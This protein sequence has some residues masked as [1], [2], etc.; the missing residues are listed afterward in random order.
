MEP[1][2]A[3]QTIEIEAIFGD[4]SVQ[5][6]LRA[7]SMV[8]GAGRE[9][10][11]VLMEDAYLTMGAVEVQSDRVVLDGTVNCQVVYCQ[12][13][14]PSAR[15]LT[16]QKT[17]NHV[18]EIPGVN[19]TMFSRTRGHVEHVDAEYE[20]GHIVFQVVV[21][22]RVQVSQLEPTDVVTMLSG[23][24]GLETQF[25][26]VCSIKLNA[27]A[28]DT[29]IVREEVALPPELDAR[30]AL[31]DWQTVHVNNSAPDI[32]G[33]RV[34]GEVMTETLIGTGV[35]G[36]PAALVKVGV[37][38][39]QLVEMPEWLTTDVTAE[40]R[41]KRLSTS[42]KANE[43]GDGTKLNIEAEMDFS[44]RSSGKDCA[45]A[46][47]DAYSTG[48][49]MVVAK[50]KQLPLCGGLAQFSANETFKG[51]MLM[52]DG[53]P[54]AST[55]LAARVRPTLSGWSS[56]SGYTTFEGVLEAG[57][58]Y[59]SGGSDRLSATRAEMPFSIR[60]ADVIPEDAWVELN[61]YAAEANALMSDRM[62]FKCMMSL[63]GL[64]RRDCVSGVVNEITVTDAPP[65]E[66]GMVLVWPG[67]S[68]TLWSVGKRYRLPPEE[69]TAIN[70]GIEQL[71][72]GKAVLLRL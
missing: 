60:I 62:E 58:L 30:I 55:V 59:M 15:A 44:V 19:A 8:P 1:T 10:I 33:V 29:A 36:R 5:L 47:V 35:P 39:D 20:N 34:T 69:I 67:K 42:L 53:V 28:R 13:E 43:E 31:M 9:A 52:R 38:F 22:L 57:V 2:K 61:A 65:R 3:K 23:I 7:E 24:D 27:E 11:E 54:G 51:T 45:M 68:D 70:G 37:P 71:I 63:S 21:N 32:G 41:V 50:H 64:T 12:G 14:D 16:A 66:R 18:I 4:E 49:R 46:L 56:Q 48:E 25:E 17:F 6:P 26:E 72:E 40:A